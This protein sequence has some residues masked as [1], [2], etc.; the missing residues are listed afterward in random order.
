FAHMISQIIDFRSRFTATHSSGVAAA[1]AAIASCLGFSEKECRLIYVAGLLHDL[2]K[3]AIPDQILEK[4]GTLSQEEFA[5]IRSHTYYT[6]HSLTAIEGLE[7][8][9]TWAA[10][11]HERLDG[12]GYPFHLPGEKLSPQARLMAVADIYTALSED[13][14][15]RKGMERPQVERALLELVEQQAIDATI[16]NCLLDNYQAVDLARQEAQAKAV[17]A[18]DDFRETINRAVYIYRY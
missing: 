16:V 18:Y 2:G 15:Y 10:Y 1:S 13:R 5:V 17:S 12:T 11:H 3:L 7:E 4:P 6:Y 9:A 8:L 14:P